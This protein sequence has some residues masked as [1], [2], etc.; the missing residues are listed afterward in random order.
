MP[1][2]DPQ[3]CCFDAWAQT[4]LRRA[5]GRGPDRLTQM[6]LTAAGRF[7]P[8]G[9]TLLDV[10]CGAGALAVAAVHAGADRATGI[11]LAPGAE[12]AAH[13]YA[14]ERGVSRSTEF[15]TGDAAEAS[16]AAHDVVTLNRVICCYPDPWALLTNTVAATRKTYIYVAPRSSGA[17]GALVRRGIGLGNRWFARHQATYGSY[18]GFVHDL[19][20]VDATIERAGLRCVHRRQ[21]HLVWQMAVFV[22][23]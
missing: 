19:R 4:D 7:G 22:R 21:I 8:S 18:Q 12:R 10:G 17:V 20:E 2:Q 6:V 5:R 11:D 14:H 1:P 9:H 16:L 3:P 23:D 15:S 13:Q